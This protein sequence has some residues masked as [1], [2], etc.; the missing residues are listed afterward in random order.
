MLQ[1]PVDVVHEGDDLLGG[2]TGAGA[3][4]R[5]TGRRWRV[6]LFLLLLHLFKSHEVDVYAQLLLA[7]VVSQ[8]VL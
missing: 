7:P 2:G 1:A 5:R 3:E 6:L 4:E 8:V